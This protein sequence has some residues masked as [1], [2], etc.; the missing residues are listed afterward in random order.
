MLSF[1]TRAPGDVYSPRSLSQAMYSH[2]TNWK[3]LHQEFSSGTMY[4]GQV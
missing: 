2:Y 1:L 4:K 3:K